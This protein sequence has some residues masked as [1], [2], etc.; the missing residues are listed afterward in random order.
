M[1]KRYLFKI[2]FEN[3]RKFIEAGYD[4]YN[5]EDLEDFIEN[6]ISNVLEKEFDITINYDKLFNREKKKENDFEI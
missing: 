2:L 5:V 1:N 6:I 4:I 3:K